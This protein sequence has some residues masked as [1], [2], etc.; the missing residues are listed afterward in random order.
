MLSLNLH[1]ALA[2][3]SLSLIPAAAM[4]QGLTIIS[5]AANRT[6]TSP[7]RVVADF[8]NTTGIVSTTVSVDNVDTPGGNVTPLDMNMPMSEGNHFLTITGVQTDGSTVTAS[9]WVKVGAPA[10]AAALSTQSASPLST[11]ST[12][13]YSSIEQM[14]GWYLY[15]DL[16]HPVCSSTPSLVK[17]PSISSPSGKFYLGPTGQYNNCLWPI[18][19]GSSTKVSN[20]KLDAYYQLSNPAYSQGI[21]FSSNH[22]VGTKWYKFSVQCSYFKGHFSVWDT[23]G[24]RWSATSIPCKRPALGS[25]DHLTVNTSISNG[26]AVFTSL[27]LNGVTHPINQSFYPSTKSTSAS[28]GVHFQMNGDLQRH[29]Y[30]AY[31]DQFTYTAW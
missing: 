23:K 15:P 9:E 5:P 4:G 16:G 30:Y 1:R 8:P 25:W 7:V 26:K 27:T 2:L 29:P 20:F 17:A 10:T 21:E 14:S 3:F 31:V 13:T 19:L 22:H 18:L 12:L 11:S 28:L 6:V 24:G